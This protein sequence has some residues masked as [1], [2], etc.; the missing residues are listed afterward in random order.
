MSL[1]NSEVRKSLAQMNAQIFALYGENLTSL[2]LNSFSGSDDPEMCGQ[3]MLNALA[4]ASIKKI[5][6]VTHL[7]LNNNP[8]WW[9]DETCPVRLVTF[10][11]QQRSLKTVTLS[12]NQFT[13]DLT[14]QLLGSLV[15]LCH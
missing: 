8:S 12:K 7:Y 9:R 14:E 10:I 15:S 13:S 4:F 2:C 1:T 6:K 3:L 5:K 11:G